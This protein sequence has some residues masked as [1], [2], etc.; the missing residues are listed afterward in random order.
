MKKSGAFAKHSACPTA[1]IG[2]VRFSTFSKEELEAWS[3]AEITEPKLYEGD[4]PTVGG[5]NDLR[6]GI[7]SLEQSCLTCGE[8]RECQGHFGH[9]RLVEAVYHYGFVG[10]VEKVLKCICHNCSLLKIFTVTPP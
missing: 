5:P 6:L 2:F 10:Y 8:K 7:N 1:E 4:R 3:V 9:I